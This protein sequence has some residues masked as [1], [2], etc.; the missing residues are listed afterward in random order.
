MAFLRLRS[1]EMRFSVVGR[2]V[3]NFSRDRGFL[4]FWAL[5]DCWTVRVKAASQLDVLEDVSVGNDCLKFLL[6]TTRK[7]ALP[8]DILKISTPG[9]DLD[10]SVR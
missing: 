10:V 9:W 5:L 7:G 2:I 4:N 3:F 1:S 6:R 8:Q